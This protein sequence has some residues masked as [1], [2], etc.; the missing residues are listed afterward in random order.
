MDVKCSTPHPA[1]KNKTAL[2]GGMMNFLCVR[3]KLQAIIALEMIS[4]SV[5]E[6][7]Y[8]FVGLFQHGYDE[9]HG[10]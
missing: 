10:L 3:T 9:D 6:T 4:Q 1:A 5:I 7:P 8:I 2:A